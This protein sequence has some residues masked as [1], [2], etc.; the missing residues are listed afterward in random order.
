MII[1][2]DA[3]SAS[4]EWNKDMSKL[5]MLSNGRISTIDLKANRN[6]PISIRGELTIDTRQ[7][8][9]AM[10][11]HVWNRTKAMFYTS[12]FHGAPWDLLRDEYKPKVD[13]VGNDFEMAELL[14]EMLGELNVSHSGARYRHRASN[15]TS[16]ASLGIFIDYSHT[17]NGLKIAEILKFG[18][19][20]KNHLNIKPGMIINKI[21]GE[22]I[23][24]NID[25]AKF[26]NR[27]AG[28][29]TALEVFDPEKETTFQITV[30]PISQGEE[31]SLLYNRWVKQNEEMVA[32]L[33]NGQLGYVHV[34]GMSDGPYRNIYEKAMGKY[35]NTKGLI[36]DTR[37]NGGGDLVSDIAMFLTGER[38]IEYAI[39]DRSLGF[40][41]TARWT[42]P[43][44]ALANEANYSDGHC[45]ACGYKD[46]GIGKLIGM[47]VPGTCSFAGWEMLQ[48]GKIMWGAVP[49]SAK[50]KA[51]EWLENNE[52]IPD[53]I[54][55]NMPNEIANGHDEQLKVAI[56]ELL[57][58]I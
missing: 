45:F 9:H 33:S 4:L 13:L 16:T 43:S 29:F 27:K 31:N 47:P 19:L 30:K 7:E 53:I 15:G 44:V 52:A 49:V 39:E 34:P 40:E 22:T 32:E 55:K 8:R 57:K 6:K 12:D 10:F 36:I 48:N 3:R 50:N 42:K 54:V 56:E 26:L 24:N 21:D 28:D 37:F 25:Y 35:S 2:L 58:D 38:F 41:P 51:G 20:D 14:S 46:L 1:P 17:A 11:N 18:P 5:F 23:T